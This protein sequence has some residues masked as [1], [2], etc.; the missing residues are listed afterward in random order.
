VA[1]VRAT[2]SEVR[3]LNWRK[4]ITRDD[5]GDGTASVLSCT[6]SHLHKRRGAVPLF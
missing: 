3:C 5:R 2:C 1:V 6:A 4:V